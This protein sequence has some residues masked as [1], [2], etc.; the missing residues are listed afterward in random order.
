MWSHPCTNKIHERKLQWT[1]Q[2]PD[3]NGLTN[4]RLIIKNNEVGFFN[5]QKN[6]IMLVFFI[7]LILFFLIKLPFYLLG[8][9]KACVLI[10]NVLASFEMEEILFEL[11]DHSLGLNCGIWD[12]SASFVNKFGKYSIYLFMTWSF[13]RKL[14][15]I[16]VVF[17]CV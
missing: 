3:A 11:K 12:Y 5:T 17:I 9:I 1:R 14:E 8:T 16:I 4:Y 13:H 7:I 6:R 15:S 2:L 10:E